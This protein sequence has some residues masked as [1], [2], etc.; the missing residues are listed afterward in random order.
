MRSAMHLILFLNFVH[1]RAEVLS[2]GAPM[3]ALAGI[4]L[5]YSH[6]NIRLVPP[7]GVGCCWGQFDFIETVGAGQGSALSHVAVLCASR[8]YAVSV[9]FSFRYL[10]RL[11]DVGGQWTIK[12]N[13]TQPNAKC[14]TAIQ[15]RPGPCIGFSAT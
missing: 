2:Q 4:L 3:R 14:L 9:P 10:T 13:G 11:I 8:S 5:D 7:L 6:T 15:L 12:G 1:P